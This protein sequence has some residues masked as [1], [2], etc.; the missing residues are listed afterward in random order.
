MQTTPRILWRALCG[1]VLVSAMVLSGCQSAD[2]VSSPPASTAPVATSAAPV[3]SAAQTPT[4]T[5]TPTTPSR[6][7]VTARPTTPEETAALV[8]EAEHVYLEMRR[9]MDEY[10]AQG[11]AATLPAPLKEY[12]GGE[13]AEGLELALKHLQER[14]QR[15]IGSTPVHRQEVFTTTSHPSSLLGVEFCEDWTQRT[16]VDE[17][18]KQA[19]AQMKFSNRAEFARAGDGKLRIVGNDGKENPECGS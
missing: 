7:V 18:G 2:R 9:L 1:V 14:G 3:G 15:T 12:V 13:Y 10:E 11:G 5:P 19:L 4:A 16:L 6:L 17:K 8:A